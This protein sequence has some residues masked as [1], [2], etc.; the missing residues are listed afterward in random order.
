M[1]WEEH[2]ITF[3]DCR[4]VNNWRLEHTHNLLWG[5]GSDK[6]YPKHH[7]GSF[8]LSRTFLIPPVSCYNWLSKWA[9]SWN[10]IWPKLHRF[11]LREITHLSRCIYIT[12]FAVQNKSYLFVKRLAHLFSWSI[13]FYSCAARQCLCGSWLVARFLRSTRGSMPVFEQ[14]TSYIARQRRKSSHQPGS[15]LPW[16][17]HFLEKTASVIGFIMVRRLVTV[18]NLKWTMCVSSLFMNA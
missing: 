16:L 10:W 3:L 13:C 15:R 8:S 6:N 14:V 5:H 1:L 17:T 4:L 9:S 12:T 11:W 18:A 2:H 7:H